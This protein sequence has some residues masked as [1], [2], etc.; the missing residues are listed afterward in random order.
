MAER[1]HPDDPGFRR[2][3]QLCFRKGIIPWVSIRQNPYRSA[4]FWRYKY[5]ARF[6]RNREVLD[7]PCGVGWGTSLCK[8]CRSLT[9]VDISEEAIAEARKRYGYLAN[10]ELGSMDNLRYPDASFDLVSCLEGIEHVSEEVGRH[11]IEGAHRVLRDGGELILSSPYCLDGGHSG[12]VYHLVEYR[13]EE[14]RAL[15]IRYFNIEEEQ[16]RKVGNLVVT[17]IRGRRIG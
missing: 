7:I 12:N 9:G 10:F 15:L 17:L 11:F 6:C 3:L 4:F 5:V 2:R 14:L 16:E 13:P 8:H 1:A